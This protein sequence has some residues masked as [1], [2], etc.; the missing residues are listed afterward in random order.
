VNNSSQQQNSYLRTQRSF[1][2]GEVDKLSAEIDRTY[3]DIA[4]K[5]NNRTIG[6]FAVDIARVTGENWFLKGSSK[7]QQTLRRVYVFSTI[8]PQAHYI[9]FNATTALTRIYGTFTDGVNWY[10]LPYVDVTA[11]TN[12]VNVTINPTQIVITPAPGAPYFD[13][14]LVVLEWLSQF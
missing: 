5:V 12:Q 1:P 7:K 10:P 4:Q 2:T 14:G 9:D 8:D 11:V 3:I 6:T 13:N